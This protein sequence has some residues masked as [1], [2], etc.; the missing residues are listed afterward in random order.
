MH[1]QIESIKIF[2]LP[3]YD[4]LLDERFKF[5]C[6]KKLHVIRTVD[7]KAIEVFIQRHADT[8]EEISIRCGGI[9]KKRKLQIFTAIENCKRLKYL[10]LMS[11]F[12][13][14]YNDFYE[15]LKKTDQWIFKTSKREWSEQGSEVCHKYRFPDDFAVFKRIYSTADHEPNQGAILKVCGKRRN[16]RCALI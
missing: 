14:V 4:V 10:C 12:E 9:V 11:G 5:P 6:L 2:K 7:E 15:L 8:L 16:S 1:P 3:L 13:L